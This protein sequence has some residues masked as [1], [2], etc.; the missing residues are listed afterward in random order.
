M[1]EPIEW[2]VIVAGAWNLALLTPSWLQRRVFERP[3]AALQLHRCRPESA[4]ASAARSDVD[5]GLP[6]PTDCGRG[7]PLLRHPPQGA[8]SRVAGVGDL[9]GNAYR[10]RRHQ[11]AV[12]PRRPSLGSRDSLNRTTR[13]APYGM[14]PTGA[15]EAAPPSD[16]LQRWGLELLAH[17]SRTGA[18]VV[19][20]NFH[21]DARDSATARRW[22]ELSESQ[23]K[24]MVDRI[25]KDLSRGQQC[26]LTGP[27]GRRVQRSLRATRGPAEVIARRPPGVHERDRR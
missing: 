24:G 14:W 26:E 19:A 20:F 4:T 21:Y 12:Q 18:R 16:C 13:P 23:M 6:R 3:D 9:V 25:M 2:N 17:R 8:G 27:T 7:R 22:L 11:C 10:W 15:I 1:P 5:C